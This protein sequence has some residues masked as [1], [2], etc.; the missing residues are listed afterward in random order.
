MILLSMD[1]NNLKLYNDT[2]G[3]GAGDKALVTVT[4]IMIEVFSKYAKLFRT[5]GDEFMAIFSKQDSALAEKL[6]QEF[7]NKLSKTEYRVACGIAQYVPGDDIEKI[8][9]LSDEKMYAHKVLLKK[10]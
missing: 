8:I 6:V 4:E 2:K 3:H 10:A 9:T 5:G 1:L 7:Q